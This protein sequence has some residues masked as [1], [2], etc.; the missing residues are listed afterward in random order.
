MTKLKRFNVENYCGYRKASFD[1]TDGANPKP[2]AV[3]YGPNGIGKS[4]LINGVKLV[5]EASRY[6]SR[7]MD[8]AFR[9]MVFNV[10]Y[11]PDNAMYKHELIHKSDEKSWTSQAERM[12][13]KS[14]YELQGMKIEAIF[15]HNGEEKTVLFNDCG[16]VKNELPRKA[17]SYC[18]YID[19]DHPMNMNKFQLSEVYKDRFLELAKVVYNMNVEL[20]APV[21][22]RSQRQVEETFFSDLVIDKYGVK[23]HFKSMSAGEKKI[24]TLLAGLC[25]PNYI[26]DT[27]IIIVDNVAMHIY[28]KRHIGMVNKLMEIYSDKQFFLTTHSGVLIEALDN[29]YLYDLEDYVKYDEGY[30]N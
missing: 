20:R 6:T 7:P 27:N 13:L 19:A 2:L 30:L 22:A 18:Y 26:D 9:K 24:A 14:D 3:F 1:F 25:D 15:D 16:L 29:Q 11:N 21:K 8:I 12:K 23:V 17:E 5:G 28:F 4:S 10:D